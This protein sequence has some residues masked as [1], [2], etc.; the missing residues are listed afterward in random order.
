MGMMAT[1]TELGQGLVLRYLHVI[2]SKQPQAAGTDV[3]L[4][5]FLLGVQFNLHVVPGGSAFGAACVAAASHSYMRSVDNGTYRGGP[6][7]LARPSPAR[8][9][10]PRRASQDGGRRRASFSAS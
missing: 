6:P 8:R 10:P 5:P 9:F 4:P 3:I 2:P 7:G 1:A